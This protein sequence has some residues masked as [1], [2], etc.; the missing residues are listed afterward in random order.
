MRIY[1]PEV[2]PAPAPAPAATTPPR[3]AGVVGSDALDRMVGETLKL[4]LA[5]GRVRV[6]VL[7]GHSPEALRMRVRLRSGEATVDIPRS[8]IVEIGTLPR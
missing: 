5:D 8:N 2:A 4:R 7:E 3:P 1:P 6:G